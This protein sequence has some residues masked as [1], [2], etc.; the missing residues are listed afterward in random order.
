MVIRKKITIIDREKNN[1]H[2]PG[3]CGL[4]DPIQLLCRRQES[5]RPHRAGPPPGRALG[6]RWRRCR[7]RCWR[8]GWRAA[9]LSG[10]GWRPGLTADTRWSN[11]DDDGND[12]DT[13]YKKTIITINDGDDN[14]SWGIN[15]TSC[16]GKHQVS[17]N[18]SIYLLYHLCIYLKAAP[19]II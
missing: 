4:P 2:V 7:W 19:A 14:F 10:P 13:N 3:V 5:Q 17:L 16:L 6:G 12:N 15:N 8:G 9:T 11:K 18:P 1:S